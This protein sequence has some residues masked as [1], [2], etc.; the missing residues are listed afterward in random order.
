[1]RCSPTT[2]NRYFIYLTLSTAVMSSTGPMTLL[3]PKG[4]IYDEGLLGAMKI[5]RNALKK[6]NRPQF[7][8]MF[9]HFR[10]NRGKLNYIAV[11][12]VK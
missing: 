8:R 12:S 1:M 2:G 3:S 9:R 10:Q 7:L 4:L 6:E 5:I 11:V